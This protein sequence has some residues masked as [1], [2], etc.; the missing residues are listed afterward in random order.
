MSFVFN[1]SFLFNL[2]INLSVYNYVYKMCKNYQAEP[3]NHYYLQAYSSGELL[4]GHLK[5]ELIEILQR[6]VKDH[7]ERRNKVTEEVVLEYMKP[8]KLKFDY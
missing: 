6:I 2:L 8:R 3:F 1:V 7:Q 5:K 4:T